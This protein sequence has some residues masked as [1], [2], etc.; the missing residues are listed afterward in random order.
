M[1]KFAHACSSTRLM[2]SLAVALATFA[3]GHPEAQ[4]AMAQ[5][6]TSQT[7]PSTQNRDEAKRLV[8]LGDQYARGQGVARD[9]A[10][11]A[12]H[13]AKAAE[14]GD[15]AGML[16]FGE[17]LVYGRGVAVDRE[18]GIGL[19]ESAVRAG[20]TAA[21]VSLSDVIARGL[22]GRDNRQ[23]AITLLEQA[24]EKGQAVAWVKLGAIYE[25]GKLTPKDS[26]R[27]AEYYQ[28]AIA[29]D[30]ADAMV[31]L[32]RAL[33]ERRLKG[34][35]TRAEGIALLRK[36]QERGNENAVIAL[37]DAHFNGNGVPR[38][39]KQALSLL[40]EGWKAG[41]MRAG[42]RLVALYR[43]GRGRIL[44]PNPRR[45]RMILDAI[46]S[47]LPPQELRAERLLIATSEAMTRAEREAVRNEFTKLPAAEQAA[48]IRRIRSANQNVYVYLVQE[49]L[50]QQG[51]LE[52]RASGFL[53]QST[54]R[55][56]HKNCLIY[57]TADVC[58]RGPLT[59]PVVDATSQLFLS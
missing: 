31:S 39:S 4:T 58:R 5:T 12:R 44:K 2:L 9:E 59:S 52:G 46:A 49:E 1:R 25:A 8:A 53:S 33:A 19:I 10:E 34:Q 47:K 28:K 29:A 6:G 21:M 16:R 17:A 55:A 57:E 26:R 14:L 7:E 27:A 13:Y 38:S 56:I 23:R 50:R 11:A 30:R 20:N 37:S 35:G 51:L 36:A 22:A 43:D 3:A 54:I 15:P 48:L 41:N 24:A 18:R 32:G 42:S 40:T 45:A